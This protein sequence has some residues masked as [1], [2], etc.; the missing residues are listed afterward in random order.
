MG[1]MPM[2]PLGSAL[3]PGAFLPLHVFEPR[4]RQMIKDILADDV[5]PP[6]FGVT[7]IER[8]F[9]VGG[10]DERTEVG[11]VARILD[12]EVTDD[13]RY[14]VASVGA[15]RIRVNRW[16]PDDPYPLADVDDW[17]DD[18]AV[19]DDVGERISTLHD[20]VKELNESVRALGELT[21][22]ADSEISDEPELAVYHLGALAPLGPADRYRMLACPGLAE[23]LD[24]LAAA[25][26]DAAAVLE[27][28]SS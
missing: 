4:Y 7:M 24:V 12:I 17:P 22:P 3:L 6:E 8:G 5:N 18:G 13:G 28:R 9:E 19:P 26:D 16:L 14:G 2:F 11:T 25:L 10:G 21:P 15:R 27:F 23:R 20:R 1:V